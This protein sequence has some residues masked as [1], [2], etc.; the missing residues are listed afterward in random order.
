MLTGSNYDAD[1]ARRD[2]APAEV[3]LEVISDPAETK[4]LYLEAAAMAT[5]MRNSYQAWGARHRVN[6]YYQVPDARME[7]KKSRRKRLLLNAPR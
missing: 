2:V 7:K 4:N 5:S 3:L 6:P 1:K